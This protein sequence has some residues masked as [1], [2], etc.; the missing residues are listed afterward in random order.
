[1]YIYTRVCVCIYIMYYNTY[2]H[3]YTYNDM[4]VTCK[5]FF[6]FKY[7]AVYLYTCV[8]CK[9]CTLCWLLSYCLSDPTP[10]SYT[11]LCKTGAGTLQTTFLPCQPL[12]CIHQRQQLEGDWEVWTH[13]LC[14]FPVG[15]LFL[16]EASFSGSIWTQLVVFLKNTQDL[17]PCSSHWH[18][19][20]GVWGRVSK[21]RV[22][23]TAQRAA[24]LSLGSAF[25]HAGPRPQASTLSDEPLAFAVQMK[26]S[27]LLLALVP[28]TIT[29][30]FV[31]FIAKWIMLHQVN[32]IKTFIF[33][34]PDW[35]PI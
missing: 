28:S 29:S 3:A 21:L 1:M 17:C 8:R 22:T 9:W 23:G 2:T 19:D 4:E 14:S 33:L 20:S 24:C 13:F 34:S 32:I 10:S 30:P 5:K 7:S 6:W 16:R 25:T 31:F 27:Q 26:V 18:P 11:Q 35:T 15:F 12:H